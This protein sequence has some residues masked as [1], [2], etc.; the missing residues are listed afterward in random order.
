MDELA[1]KFEE[2]EEE[3]FG[4]D[5]FEAA[6]TRMNEIEQSLGLDKLEMFTAPPP[7]SHS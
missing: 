4:E 5:G 7:P 2:I 6:A 1:V 3:I